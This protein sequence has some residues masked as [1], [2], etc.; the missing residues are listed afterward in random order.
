MKQIRIKHLFFES[1]V[2]SAMTDADTFIIYDHL[3]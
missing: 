3:Y 1:I 2:F